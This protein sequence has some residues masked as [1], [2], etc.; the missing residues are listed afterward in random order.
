MQY[1]SPHLESISPAGTKAPVTMMK[2]RLRD[3]SNEAAIVNI[4]VAPNV[5]FLKT[6]LSRKQKIFTF[7]QLHEA[8]DQYSVLSFTT[9]V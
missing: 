7:S 9:L 3:G 5:N 4:T 6:V 8:I 1:E 2:R